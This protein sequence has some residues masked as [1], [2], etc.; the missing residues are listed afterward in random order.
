PGA[1]DDL[2]RDVRDELGIASPFV[3]V[4]RI[5][6]RTRAELDRNAIR[7]RGDFSAELAR[8]V[9][10]LRADPAALAELMAAPPAARLLDADTVDSAES[11]LIEAEE[12]ALELLESGQER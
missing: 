7:R 9:D 12:R 8:L 4:D 5:I 10:D 2:L 1:A 6:D 11:L 3:W